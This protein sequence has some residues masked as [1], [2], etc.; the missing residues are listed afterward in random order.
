MSEAANS[1]S[2]TMRA[3]INPELAGAPAANSRA[4]MQKQAQNL[5]SWI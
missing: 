5:R 1:A 3:Q 4:A 2:G